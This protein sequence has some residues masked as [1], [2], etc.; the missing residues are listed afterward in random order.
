[1]DA[2]S[3]G[4]LEDV[5]G[6]HV[7]D[8]GFRGNP[9]FWDSLNADIHKR[10]KRKP[11]WLAA[12]SL[13]NKGLRP[14]VAR[15]ERVHRLQIAEDKAAGSLVFSVTGLPDS[16]PESDLCDCT[17]SVTNSSQAPIP[18]SSEQFFPQFDGGGMVSIRPHAKLPA[19]LQP[20]QTLAETIVLRLAGDQDTVTLRWGERRSRNSVAP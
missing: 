13:T 5:D 9:G 15:K 2:S 10:R 18:I 4:Q 19:P 3:T 11:V 17:A 12:Y 20:G 6:D 16:L 14:I 7:P 8:I 1:M